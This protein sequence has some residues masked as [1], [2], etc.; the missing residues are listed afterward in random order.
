M[1]KSVWVTA[2]TLTG[3]VIGAGILGLPYVF[4]QSGFLI[5]SF[6]LLVLGAVMIY[7]NLA[8]GEVTLRTKGVHHL[9]GLAER[10]L[11]K[12][13]KTIMFLS[14]AFGIY[15]ALLAYLVG[16]GESLSRLI[17]GSGDYAVYF[18]I[19]FCPLMT[20]LLGEGLRA[21]KKVESYG[22]IVIII[23]ILGIFVWLVPGIEVGNLSEIDYGNFLF[24][25]GVVLFA[26]LGFS[27]IPELRRTIS[28]SEKSFRKAIVVG[29]IISIVLYFLFA[30]AF[31]GTLGKSVPE[32]ATLGFGG[33]VLLL[34]VF[35]M[36]TSYFVLSF[37]LKDVFTYDLDTEGFIRFFFVSL[38]PL[39]FYLIAYFFEIGDFVSILSIGGVVSG[40]LTA[41]LAL[42]M[43]VRAKKMGNRSPEFNVP[44]NWVG[45]V[46]LGLLFLVGVVSV[47]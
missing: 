19:G 15:S 5:G 8:I 28:G 41:V 18:G 1:R 29:M 31:V 32:V 7:V 39:V 34:G 4:A 14:L 10:Y 27:S 13:G 43:N 37:A 12:N 21:L 17:M 20:L 30:L 44:L 16:E 23:I 26:L 35:T 47:I 25:F 24:P 11:G 40:G 42:V 22:V 33:V 3:T 9:P 2:F 45:V 6:W 36:I 46:V 38:V